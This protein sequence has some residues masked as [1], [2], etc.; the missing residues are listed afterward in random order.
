[1]RGV[2][3]LC[4]MIHTWGWGMAVGWVRVRTQ[5]SVGMGTGCVL[6]ALPAGRRLT[7]ASV[8]QTRDQLADLQASNTKPGVGP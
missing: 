5:G 2:Q 1:M 6:Q 3:L 8:L 7:S 4:F